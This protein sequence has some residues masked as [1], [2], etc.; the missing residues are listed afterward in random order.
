LPRPSGVAVLV[1]VRA[2]DIL[3]SRDPVDGLSARNRIPGTIDRIVPRGPEAE[4]IVRTLGI[5]WIVSLVA[6]A[7]AQL[8]L[9]PGA[10]VHL[11]VKARSCHVIETDGPP[12]PAN[13]ANRDLP[14]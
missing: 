8:G 14:A 9:E 11:I 6:P 1:E 12:L 7:V 13:P 3:L 5:T 4:A 2:D 10:G